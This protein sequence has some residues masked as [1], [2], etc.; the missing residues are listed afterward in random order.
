MT[1]LEKLAGGDRPSLGR[2]AEVLRDI[3][4]DPTLFEEVFVGM[5]DRGCCSTRR[6]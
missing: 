3:L 6:H 5:G 4:A 1:P 2:A